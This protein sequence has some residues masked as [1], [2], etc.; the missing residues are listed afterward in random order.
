MGCGLRVIDA[1]QEESD[2]GPD[3]AAC[4]TTSEVPHPC[5]RLYH[6]VKVYPIRCLGTLGS[7]CDKH[8][9]SFI[10]SSLSE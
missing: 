2:N 7:P 8:V 9:L 4:R 3:N 5:G 6:T 10:V 1:T